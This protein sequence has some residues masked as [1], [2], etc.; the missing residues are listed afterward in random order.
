M[1][2]E[3]LEKYKNKI[4]NGTEIADFIKFE[5]QQKIKKEKI[6]KN[7]AAILIGDNKNSVT[8]LN[9][10]KKFANFINVGFCEYVINENEEE[11]NV[12]DAINFLNN[13]EEI[14]G[15]IL[16]LPIPKQFNEEKIINLIDR[17]KDIDGFLENTKFNPVLGKVIFKILQ[18]YDDDINKK[19]EITIIC[20][21][22]IFSNKI[23]SYLK[24][25][26]D[27]NINKVLFDQKNIEEIKNISKKSDIII[28]TVGKKHFITK[29]FVKDGSI[30]IDIGI[31]KEDNKV[32]GDT[33][34]LD[35]IDKVKYITPPIG[36]VGPMT[37]AMLFDNLVNG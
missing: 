9:L 36:G 6:N 12:I 28:S 4:I 34:I 20:N 32:Y 3:I 5:L 22:D 10:K 8:Y 23:E 29:D 13:D 27:A 2:K 30:I 19:R 1:E 17:K 15:I 7:L 33:N 11:N 16:Q 35:V 24:T 25:K 37:V 18:E 21:S 14:S 26:L 31:T